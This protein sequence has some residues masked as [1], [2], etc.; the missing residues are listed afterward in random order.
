M[1]HFI[2]LLACLC[3]TQIHRGYSQEAPAL[4][5]LFG[6]WQQ[7]YSGEINKEASGVVSFQMTLENTK[8]LNQAP[9]SHKN[10]RI[11]QFKDLMSYSKNGVTANCITQAPF[12]WTYEQDS[13]VLYFG[14]AFC[15]CGSA[16]EKTNASEELR[17]AEKENR[18]F[19]NYKTSRWSLEWVSETEILLDGLTF[20]KN[21]K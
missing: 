20:K 15:S 4:D 16:N 11:G 2:L 5:Q 19:Y 12:E 18:N 21:V 3:L 7:F 14:E 6:Q 10:L 9:R 1:Y 13:L 8:A 17:K